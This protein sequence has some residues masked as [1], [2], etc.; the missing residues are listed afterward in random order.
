MHITHAGWLH[1]SGCPSTLPLNVP[2]QLDN[3]Y[4]NCHPCATGHLTSIQRDFSETDCV[5]HYWMGYA[6]MKVTF[7]IKSVKATHILTAI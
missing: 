7:I 5:F 4:S 1:C 6:T 3:V 2:F